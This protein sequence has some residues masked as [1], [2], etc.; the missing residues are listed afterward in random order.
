MARVGRQVPDRLDRGRHGRGRL[1]RLG[2]PDRLGDEV[3]L[4]GDDLFVTNPA[5]LAKGHRGGHRQ[6]DPDQGQ[7]D[8]HADRDPGGGRDGPPRRLH[9]R[10]SRTARA[11]PRIRPSPTSRSR[12]TAARS[13]PARSRSD[14]LAKYNQLC[15]SSRSWAAARLRGAVAA[16]ARLRRK[17]GRMSRSEP[18]G[19]LSGWLRGPLAGGRGSRW[20]SPTSATTRCMAATASSPGSTPRATSSWRDS[21]RGSRPSAAGGG[22]VAG[23]PARFARP[24]PARGA[25]AAA[26]LC[27]PNEVV[28]LRRDEGAGL[29]SATRRR[30][31]DAWRP[32]KPCR[33]R[34]AAGSLAATVG[35]ATRGTGEERDAMAARTSAKAADKPAGK[36]GRPEPRGLLSATTARCC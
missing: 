27:Q 2:S 20:C 6:L 1:G 4:V 30:S 24:R 8:R 34:R 29:A 35:P 25:A 3:Q 12:P 23:L 11:R 18:A 5:I 15:A 14:R 26:G 13:R 17:D 31:A 22:D 21:W 16:G 32:G 9:R 33:H 36:S 7:P 28:V 10:S 19:T